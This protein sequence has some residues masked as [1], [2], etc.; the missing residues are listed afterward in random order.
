MQLQ[1][2]LGQLHG[3]SQA[4]AWL[5]QTRAS[6][7]KVPP[8]SLD[9]GASLLLWGL[10]MRPVAELAAPK[11]AWCCNTIPQDRYQKGFVRRD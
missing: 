10:S 3:S 7:A 11:V 4:A 8:A 1:A 6:Q 9:A 2:G 5:L